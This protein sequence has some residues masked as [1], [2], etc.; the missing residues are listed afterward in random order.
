MRVGEVDSVI[1]SEERGR[2]VNK[3]IDKKR[4]RE[5][6]RQSAGDMA[7]TKCVP[8]FPILGLRSAP[9]DWTRMRDMYEYAR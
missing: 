5:E 6:G 8:V 7:G 2:D 1:F 3:Q 4:R 9:R